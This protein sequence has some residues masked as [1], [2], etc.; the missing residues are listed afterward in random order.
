MDGDTL[1]GLAEWAAM[2]ACRIDPCVGGWWWWWW[3]LW[4]LVVVVA[5]VA[6]VVV[7]V[8]GVFEWG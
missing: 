6:A 1:A 8:S 4:W 7:A 5:V 2:L 3:W